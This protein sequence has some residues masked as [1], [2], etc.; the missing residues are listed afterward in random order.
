M[1]VAIIVQKM[2]IRQRGLSIFSAMSF[3]PT[4]NNEKL[5]FYMNIRLYIPYIQGNIRPLYFRPFRPP[6]LR[7]NLSLGKLHWLKLFFF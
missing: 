2:I 5:C 7:A 4:S 6:C 3:Y 1:H